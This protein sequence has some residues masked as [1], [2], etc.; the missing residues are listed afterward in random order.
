MQRRR[1]DM[2][3]IISPKAGEI[4]LAEAHAL[5][6]HRVEDGCEIARR[7]VDDAKDFGGRGLLFQR[8]AR[9][10]NESR[11]LHRDDRL[12]RKILQQ[13]NLLVAERAYFLSINHKVAE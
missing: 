6:E 13:R 2:L 5:L 8:F 9:L 7:G 12:R 11:V 10:G 3:T 1:T 4:G